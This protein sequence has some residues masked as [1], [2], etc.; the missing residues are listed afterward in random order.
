[1]ARYQYFSMKPQQRS[2]LGQVVAGI[3]GIVVLAVSLLLGAFFLAAIFGFFLIV[4]T[5]M[6]VRIWWWKRKMAAGAT[7]DPF[8]E[9][10]YS[11]V[12]T[13]KITRE[14]VRKD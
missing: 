14:T 8:I 4:G 2:L 6:W 3:V 7:D 5:I 12:Q 11:V 9:G 10:E 13:E 1:M